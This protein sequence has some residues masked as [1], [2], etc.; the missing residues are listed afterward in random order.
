M[1]AWPPLV[2]CEFGDVRAAVFD[3]SGPRVRAAKVKR[4]VGRP[5][6]T[7]SVISIGAAGVDDIDQLVVLE[8]QLFHEDA[9]VHSNYADVTW[10]EREGRADLE[11][12]L[13]DA[14]SLVLVARDGDEA[15]GLLVGYIS[16]P[17]P[18][19]RPVTFAVLRTLY[20]AS[21]QRRQRV[22]HLLTG[23]FVTWAREQGCVEAHVDSYTANE[24]AQQFYEQHGFLSHSV[25]RVLPL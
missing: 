25:S 9:G 21:G 1:P 6:Y 11:Q 10:P 23:R 5:V 24:P 7:R 3:T 18:T 16:Q 8:S 14:A 22:G 17:S 12:L 2:L 15:V 20:V 4:M 19:R 13:A